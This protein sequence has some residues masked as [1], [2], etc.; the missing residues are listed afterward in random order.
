MQLQLFLGPLRYVQALQRACF[1]VST[2]Q[3]SLGCH[4]EEIGCQSYNHRRIHSKLQI[5]EPLKEVSE[6]KDLPEPIDP[7]TFLIL[8]E[9]NYFEMGDSHFR[10]AGGSDGDNVSDGNYVEDDDEATE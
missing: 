2:H 3:T 7:F 4:Q 5:K 10:G 8:D 6:A 1:H 9:L